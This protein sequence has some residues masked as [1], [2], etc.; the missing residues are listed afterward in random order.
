MPPAT[1]LD[2]GVSVSRVMTKEELCLFEQVASPCGIIIFGASGD[3]THRKLLPSLFTLAQEN[4]LPKQFYILGVARSSMSDAAFQAKALESLGSSGTPAARAEFV[5]HCGY[6]SG[7]YDDSKTYD[8]LKGRLTRLDQTYETAGRHLFYLSTPPTLYALVAGRLGGSGLAESPKNDSWVRIV[9][10]KPFGSSLETAVQLNVAL[11]KV[12]QENQIYRIDHYLGKET[13]QNILM[14]RFANAIYEA[15]WNKHYIDHVQITAAESDGVEHRAGYYEQAGALR[16]MFQNH[17]F[18]LLSLV[19]MESPASMAADAVRDEKSKVLSSLCFPK[20]SEWTDGAVRGQYVAGLLNGKNV[21]DYRQEP[22]VQPTSTTE[23][24][25]ALKVQIDNWRWH[26]VPFYLRSGKRM[27]TRTT[28]IRVVF[29]HVPTSVFQ[30]LLADQISP[31]I[32][33]FRIQPDEGIALRFEA[34]HPGP[35]FCM[36]SVTMHFDYEEAFGVRPPEA[37]ARLFHDVMIG[38]QTLFSRQDWLESSWRFMDPILERWKNEKQNG[39]AFYPAGSWGPA[40][41]EQMLEKD[42]R[43]WLAD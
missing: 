28:D 37:Y 6:L 36:S 42:G 38:D 32:L 40:E 34:K 35:K 30:P 5:K 11:R 23:T 17:L 12:F 14:F 9:L 22:G 41:A 7:E 39:L 29:K 16:D 4:L 25:A 31:N 1:L 21:A 18:Q 43:R 33:H 15:V 3:L 20:G 26:G 8:A 2:P 19:A 24:F 10:E 27:K 13:V